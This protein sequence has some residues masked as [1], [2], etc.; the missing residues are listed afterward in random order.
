M[1]GVRAV[2]GSAKAPMAAD[3]HPAPKRDKGDKPHPRRAGKRKPDTETA[4]DEAHRLD[5]EA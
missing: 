2:A 4:R 5:V 1:S 3:Q